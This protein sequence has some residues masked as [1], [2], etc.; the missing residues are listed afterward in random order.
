MV[1]VISYSQGIKWKII[2]VDAMS[3]IQKYNVLSM[4][5]LIIFHVGS[6]KDNYE[7]LLMGKRLKK[8]TLSLRWLVNNLAELTAS[9]LSKWL[10]RTKHVRIFSMSFGVTKYWRLFKSVCPRDLDHLWASSRMISGLTPNQIHSSICLTKSGHTV[11]KCTS[12]VIFLFF[13]LSF[14][15]QHCFLNTILHFPLHS[16]EENIY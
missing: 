11:W 13:P 10:R 2:L 14:F 15:T 4:S 5:V 3:G 16:G 7:F 1:I 8:T 9:S 6:L 12:T